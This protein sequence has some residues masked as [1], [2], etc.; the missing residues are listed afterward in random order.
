MSDCEHDERCHADMLRRLEAL[1]RGLSDARNPT[2][3]EIDAAWQRIGLLESVFG[4]LFY[5]VDKSSLPGNFFTNADAHM[6][7]A[8]RLMS[9]ARETSGYYPPK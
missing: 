5:K 7:E 2:R 3:E 4:H 1:E 6:R 8:R 9:G